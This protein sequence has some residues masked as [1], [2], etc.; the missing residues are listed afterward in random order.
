MIVVF[1]ILYMYK[2]G[3][4]PAFSSELSSE[5]HD[6]ILISGI[7]FVLLLYDHSQVVWSPLSALRSP[8]AALRSQL[9][10]LSWRQQIDVND[11][12]VL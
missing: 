6:D 5:C 11:E 3:I 9:S 2:S 10:A 8:L 4:H 1:R 12:L 7:L